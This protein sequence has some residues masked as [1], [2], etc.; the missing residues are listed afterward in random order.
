[1]TTNEHDTGPQIDIDAA[2]QLVAMLEQDLAKLNGSTQDIARLKD[3][4]QALKNILGA[5]AHRHDTVRT[6]LHDIRQSL[7]QAFETAY[8]EGLKDSQYVAE[9]GRILGL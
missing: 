6:R 7:Q 8:A 9:I 1:M 4:V 2:A 3:D 5:P